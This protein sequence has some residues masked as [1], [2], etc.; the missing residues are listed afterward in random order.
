MSTQTVQ[1]TLKN[2]LNYIVCKL[3]AIS[4]LKPNYIKARLQWA[5]RH[6]QDD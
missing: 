2:K 4:L 1:R 3:R 5:L 6:N